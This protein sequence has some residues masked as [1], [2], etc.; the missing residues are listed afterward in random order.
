MRCRVQ[1]ESC[2]FVNNHAAPFYYRNTKIQKNITSSNATHTITALLHHSLVHH[3][4]EG[5]PPASKL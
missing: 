1:I 5:E 2:R 4:V 3:P